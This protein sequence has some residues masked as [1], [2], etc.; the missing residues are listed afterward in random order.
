MIILVLFD[1][2]RFGRDR[3]GCGSSGTCTCGG[4]RRWCCHYGDRKGTS[5]PLGE[6]GRVPQV[7]EA[8]GTAAESTEEASCR[9]LESE[10]RIATLPFPDELLSI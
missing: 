4:G 10:A 9:R 7:R 5:W 3:Q 2:T 8:D 1:I 6:V